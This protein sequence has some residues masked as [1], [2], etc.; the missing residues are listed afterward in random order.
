MDI[1]LRYDFD[2]ILPLV[3]KFRSIVRAGYRGPDQRA[4]LQ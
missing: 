4:C 3:E 2:I 1:I